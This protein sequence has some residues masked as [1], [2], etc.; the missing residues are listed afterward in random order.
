MVDQLVSQVESAPLWELPMW[1]AWVNARRQTL[2]QEL[3]AQR[4]IDAYQLPPSV[5]QPFEL[6]LADVDDD[7]AKLYRRLLARLDASAELAR[8]RMG[9]DLRLPPLS[10]N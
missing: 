1:L 3:G 10:E 5:M 4:L 6:D 9:Q 8:K 2:I 7:V